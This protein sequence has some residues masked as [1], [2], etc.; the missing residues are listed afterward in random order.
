VIEEEEAEGDN[1]RATSRKPRAMREEE[2]RK[3]F[4][5]LSWSPTLAANS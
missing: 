3:N 5:K 4:K 1:I 2:K